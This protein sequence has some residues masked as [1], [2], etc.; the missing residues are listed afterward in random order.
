MRGIDS[1][2]PATGP[3]CS[4]EKTADEKTMTAMPTMNTST[5][6]TL[7]DSSIVDAIIFIPAGQ[8]RREQCQTATGSDSGE[9]MEPHPH[10]GRAWGKR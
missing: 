1:K 10:A 5:K 3:D 8:Q 2:S 9:P 6:S 7:A 4:K